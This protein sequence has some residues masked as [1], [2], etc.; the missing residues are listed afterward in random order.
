[1]QPEL[2]NSAIENKFDAL[3]FHGTGL[4]HLPISDPEGDSIENAKLRLILEDFCAED[5]IAVVVAQTINGPINLNVYSKGRE[6]QEIGIIGHGSLCP[7]ES[8]L[9]KLHHLLSLGEG[10]DAVRNGWK[11]DLVGENPPYSKE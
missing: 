1:M 3:L 8:A 10:V 5:G 6:Q 7:P 4:G 2:V 9:I 11:E